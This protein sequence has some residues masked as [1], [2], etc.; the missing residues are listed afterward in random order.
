MFE[1]L[2]IFYS[3]ILPDSNMINLGRINV[4]CGK[5]NSGKTTVLN[6]IQ[7]KGS[8][9]L[10]RVLNSSEIDIIYNKSI[11]KTQWFGNRNFGPHNDEYRKILERAAGSR[12]MWH[13]DDDSAYF[14]EA[15]RLNNEHST[16]HGYAIDSTSIRDAFTSLF[17]RDVYEPVLI[18]PKRRLNTEH[19]FFTDAN[20]TPDGANL[21]N[22]LFHAKNQPSGSEE[23]FV[24]DEIRNAFQTISEGYSFDIFTKKNNQI[25]LMFSYLDGKWIH[26]TNCG[27]GLQDLI[28]ILY[29]SI[30]PDHEILLIEEPESHLH[31]AMQRKLFYFLRQKTEKQFF[32]TTH[33][34]VFLDHTFLDRVFFITFKDS[35]IIDDATTRAAILSDLGYSVT[36]N[37]TSDLIVLVEGPKDVPILEEFFLKKG[38]SEKYDIKTW[39][40]GGDIMDQLDLSVF[41]Q[42]YSIIA[43]IDSDPGSSHVRRKFEEGCNQHGIKVHKLERYAIENYFSLRA[44]KEVFKSQIDDSILDIDPMLKL[45]DQI[46]INVKNNNRK[47]AQEMTLEEIQETDLYNFL[48][49]VEELCQKHSH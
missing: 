10:G 34:N 30:H 31:P 16:L 43:L 48:E 15:L 7:H 46:N 19:Q 41:K 20:V 24:F 21:L 29:F 25:E 39:P 2:S 45:E 17:E 6:A 8:R 9:R 36:D 49:T 18:P 5:N 44:L 28:L 27:L 33:S 12:T 3:P 47:L 35:V 14:S 40:L 13:L 42:N 4:I 37:L 1:H 32:I 22:D 38:L 23:R 26:A 11:L